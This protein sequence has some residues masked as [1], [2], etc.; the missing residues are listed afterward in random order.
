MVK[1]FT[2]SITIGI[3][4]SALFD[5]EEAKQLRAKYGAKFYSDFMVENENVPF[6]PGYFFDVINTIKHINETVGHKLFDIILISRNNAW[7][8]MRAVKSCHHYG[9]PFS[10]AMFGNGELNPEYLKAYDINWFVT[11]NAKDA[12]KAQKIGIASCTVDPNAKGVNISEQIQRILDGHISPEK[13]AAI[14]TP[15]EEKASLLRNQFNK[16]LHVVW[17]LDRVIFDGT[18]DD[19]YGAHG[20]EKYRQ[21]ELEH[22]DTPMAD[23][24]FAPIAR[25]LGQIAGH[26]QEG[27]SP[28]IT[29]ALT[30]R[31]DEATLRAMHSLRDKGILFDGELHFM[32]GKDKD[33]ILS[34]MKKS[35]DHTVLFLDD[36]DR[37]ID[38]TKGI[39]T[40]GLV[41]KQQGSF[42]IG[43]DKKK[44]GE[45]ASALAAAAAKDA[46][47]APKGTPAND[48]KAKAPAVKRTPK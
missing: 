12:E 17:D 19:V 25:I 23:G 7:T 13:Q 36:S 34:I 14:V 2:K 15:A 9:I 39:V 4:T 21:Y 33:K 30:A 11:T 24:P 5:M 47:I 6:R 32:G 48:G 35:P 42:S 20:L 18:S 38:M 43:D 16:K 40:S 3:S 28:I 1:E 26:F 8:G 29:T 44:A 10:S 31:G 27:H 22:A 37:T 45:A 46:V 41:P